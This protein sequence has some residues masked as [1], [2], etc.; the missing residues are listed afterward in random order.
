MFSLVLKEMGKNVLSADS[1]LFMEI[2]LF[3][4]QNL[5]CLAIERKQSLVKNED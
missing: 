4:D 1:F 3:L 2:V 5:G